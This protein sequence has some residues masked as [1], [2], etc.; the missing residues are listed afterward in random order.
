MPSAAKPYI[1]RPNT[2][3]GSPNSAAI[4][5]SGSIRPARSRYRFHQPLR[6]Q[7]KCSSPAGD[8]AGW[9]IDSL[10]PPAT[11]RGVAGPAVGIELGQPQV[12]AL[13]RHARMVPAQPGEPAAVG[14]QARA[15]E[16]VVAAG[17][18]RLLAG[19]QGDGD[20]RV[21]R[22]AR[23][24]VVLAHGD[25]PV[26][27]RVEHRVGVA[28]GAAAG[29]GPRRLAAAHAPDP[30]VGVVAEE[31]LAVGG[32]DEGA[33]AVLVHPVA[34]VE[35]RRVDVGAASVGGALDDDVATVL[36]RPAFAGE[37]G[38]AGDRDLAEAHGGGGQRLGAERRPPAAEGRDL[39][40][41]RRGPSVHHHRADR[42]AAL[43]Q[44]E[45]LVDVLERQA[46]GDQLVDRDLPSMYQSTIFG[47]S[48]RPRAPPKAEPFH[49]P[50]GDELERPGRDLGA[51]RR[52]ADDD[53]LG[54]SPCGSTRAPGA[55]SW[56][57]RCTRSCS[58]RRRR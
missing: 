54:P 41:R 8:Q 23:G 10:S 27:R 13:P 26:A 55:W 31:E 57:C 33:A 18:H 36:G 5:C 42:L 32:D 20:D 16:E 34:G 19:A 46:V 15:G 9:K 35:G 49:M 11:C 53:R 7:A 4:G 6:S 44:L 12:A 40:W 29:D 39:A 30:L 50:A 52:H 3:C 25:Q 22:L 1:D 43:H 45:A 37:D 14:R 47:T 58:R 17:Q 51:G 56:C 24:R 38:V 48:V 2:H 28:E 21:D